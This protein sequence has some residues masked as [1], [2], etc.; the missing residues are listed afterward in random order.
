MGF[1]LAQY[2]E[3]IAA[4][5]REL[6]IPEDYPLTCR[7]PLQV[8]CEA[9][10]D[11]EPDVFGR[12]PLLE[13]GAYAAWRK[14]KERA[15]EEGVE[16]QI[17]SAF[18]SVEYQKNI[19]TAK[20]ARGLVLADILKVNAAPG[21]SEHHTGT[22]L[23]IGCPGIEHLSEAFEDSPA[24]RWLSANAAEFGFRLSFGRS[25]PYGVLYEPWHWRFIGTK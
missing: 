23:D 19:F 22:A 18:R 10:V 6:G 5:H 1:D 8:E 25:N 16:L 7:M 17:V 13:A 12:Q 20:L 15:A 4:L 2:R 3:R 24:F 11:A 14:M 9:L 21:F